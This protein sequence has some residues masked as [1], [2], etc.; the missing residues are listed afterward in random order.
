MPTLTLRQPGRRRAVLMLEDGVRFEGRAVG[1]TGEATGEVVFHTGMTGY[2]EVVSD[3][4][5]AGQIVTFTYPQIG[6][7]GVAPEDFEATRLHLR[8]VVVREACRE[9][10]NWRSM[11]SFPELLRRR[12]IVGIEGLDT[13]AL[14]LHLR[15]TGCLRGIVSHLDFDPVSLAR[16]IAAEPSMTGAD[17][18]GSVTTEKPYIADAEGA[19]FHVVAYD[20]GIKAN[21]LR[22]LL[23][24][25]CKVHVVPADTPAEAVLAL[26]PDGVFLSNGPGDPAAVR[27]A[28]RAVERLV[29]LVPLFGICLGHQI[30][31]LALGA[32]TY[33]L[34]FGHHGANHPV[35]NLDTRKVEVT[36][37]NHGFAVREES[38]AG[39]GL[40]LT[41]RNLNDG[42]VEGFRHPEYDCFAVQYHP[43]AAP[44]PHDAGYLFRQFTERMDRRR[45]A[46]H[47]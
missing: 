11:Q 47:A 44:G 10:S 12:G 38:L 23:A 9:P 40:E 14:T 2:P 26:R 33:K 29:G 25:G 4:S 34:K 1:H 15:Q 37:H 18:T 35:L 17:L 6:N 5:Y 39:A 22:G 30:M 3:P 43:E 8:G 45:E 28:I 27:R 7:Y 32:E 46:Q 20:F 24:E 31:A 41:H 36:S 21:I 42:A 19:R 16:K 13:R